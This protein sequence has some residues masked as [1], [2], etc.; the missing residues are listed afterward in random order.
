MKRFF[1]LFLARLIDSRSL[2]SNLFVALLSHILVC[3]LIAIFGKSSENSVFVFVVGLFT[4]MLPNFICLHVLLSL[5]SSSTLSY[6]ISKPWILFLT[7]IAV[8][9][10]LVIIFTYLI[11]LSQKSKFLDDLFGEYFDFYPFLFFSFSCLLISSKRFLQN[12]SRSS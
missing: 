5:L 1:I 9:M 3:I 10:A 7:V 8:V 4:L 2:L 12:K 6:N 11:W